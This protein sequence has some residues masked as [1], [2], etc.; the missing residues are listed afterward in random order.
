MS[1]GSVWPHPDVPRIVNGVRHACARDP[2]SIAI[3]SAER[4]WSYG[5]V[6]RALDTAATTLRG[7]GV[8]PGHV[9]SVRAQ[10]VSHLPVAL[11]SVWE[12]G[13]TAAI[14]DA[15]LPAARVDECEQVVEPDW[16][17]ALDGPE[18]FT[19]TV[20]RET[21]DRAAPVLGGAPSHILF[22]SGTTGRPAAVAA[23]H[24]AIR[25]A[26]GWYAHTFS[27]GPQ[28]R[29]GLLAGLGHD[30]MLRD[31][32][33]PLLCGG[34]LAVPPPDVFAGPDRLLSFIGSAG[35][36][37]LHCTPGL[38]ELVLAAHAVAGRGLESLRLVV[39]AGA[40]LSLGTVR[41]LRAVCGA[42]VVNAYGSTET[43]Q[44]ASCEVVSETFGRYDPS[45]PDDAPVG[46]GTGVGGAELLLSE[47]AG[48]IMVR[49]PN[50]A[51]GYLAGTGAE[52]RFLPDPLGV[53]GFRAYRT[54][55]LGRRGD[56]GSIRVLGRL[57][58]QMSVNGYRVA[59]EE[60]E[61]TA[62][63]HPAVVKAVAGPVSSEGGDLVGLTVVLASPEAT[64]TRTLR[65][66]LRE[67]LPRPAVPT[68][69]RIVPELALNHNHKVSHKQ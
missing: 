45:L 50:L 4:T 49:S 18:P 47:P 27:P 37:I 43:P 66:F 46:I 2:S 38:L 42:T 11:L 25:R 40:A 7:A 29:V 12:T 5:Q 53:P 36:T 23:S 55:D 32:F 54:G 9:V 68:R 41:R 13:A 30:P 65:G 31:A 28:D 34:V 69:I 19:V 21:T 62:L 3:V 1:G 15:T 6:L 64:D 48:E 44:I 57:D 26:L 20:A 60:V 58:R 61:R 8:S 56:D 59:P 67:R 24:G 52:A 63:R 39:S 14:V 22:T 51:T 33:V 10:R 35:L 17:L 16:H